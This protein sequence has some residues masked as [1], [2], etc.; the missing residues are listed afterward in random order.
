M[1]RADEEEEEEVSD[2]IETLK[3]QLA[4]AKR[5]LETIQNSDMDGQQCRLVANDALY[6]MVVEERSARRKK[7]E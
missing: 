5:A 1:A 2:N 4:I 6:E 7:D 3:A